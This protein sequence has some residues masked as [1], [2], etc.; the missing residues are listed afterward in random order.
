MI[1]EDTGQEI[2]GHKNYWSRKIDVSLFPKREC[3]YCNG[4]IL[5]KE[6]VAI[7]Q[8]NDILKI[9]C[10][11]D[12]GEYKSV[13]CKKCIPS[14]RKINANS[15][16]Y[17]MIKFGLTIEQAKELIYSRNKSPFFKTSHSNIE[18][19]KKFQSH[20]KFSQEKKNEIQKKQDLGRN[21]WKESFIKEH[22]ISAYKKLKDTSSKEH[23]KEIYKED[24]EKYYKRKIAKTRG[25]KLTEIVTLPE[26]E[27]YLKKRGLNNKF[28][29]KLYFIQKTKNKSL[30]SK[31][32]LLE[33]KELN[34][35]T[36]PFIF[37]KDIYGENSLYND[38]DIKKVKIF[39]EKK[40]IPNNKGFV[41]N[42]I[43]N[44][45]FFRSG[46]EI[47]VYLNLLENSIKVVDTN[48]SYPNA[49]RNFYDIC[50]IDL[51][52]FKH[53]LEI[54]GNDDEKYKS[55]LKER[56]TKYGA[57]LLSK[58]HLQKLIDD[59]SSCRDLKK[60]KYNDW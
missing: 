46:Q 30:V 39:F 7:R 20:N 12:Y 34:K 5:T 45:H 22:G 52:G 58:N 8:E 24:W 27:K 21:K 25:R 43:V 13:L 2:T 57:I 37:W 4:D 54:I 41:Y 40:V 59:I 10:T 11:L 17:N 6:T 9:F 50:F 49:S 26:K 19:Y 55:K 29:L 35:I 44:G 47:D 56:E 23:F 28:D 14:H 53:Y 48:K 36:A 32:F 15:F 18:E 1:V 3:K 51:L 31:L 60:G 38:L 16:E 33:K 42:G